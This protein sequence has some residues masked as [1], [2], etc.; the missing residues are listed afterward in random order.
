MW[1]LSFLP[2]W[3]FH[4]ILLGGI[5]GIIVGTVIKNVPVKLISIGVVLLGVFI[6]GSM[7]NDAQWQEKVTEAEK[8]ALKAEVKSGQ[9]NIKLV[10]KV[11]EKI[12]VIND[13]QVVVQK[14]IVEKTVVLDAACIIPAD[15]VVIHN[16][17]AA[18]P[19]TG[20]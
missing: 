7:Y 12:K 9:E 19:E 8:R 20:K 16:K 18:K 1:I 17:A 10:T 14:E 2:D 11:V 13:V 3:F 5:V 4:L 15:A 6:E